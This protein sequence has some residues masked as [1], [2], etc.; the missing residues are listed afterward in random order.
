[1]LSLCVPAVRYEALLRWSTALLGTARGVVLCNNLST[2]AG[3]VSR[4]RRAANKHPSQQALVGAGCAAGQPAPSPAT[5]E[6]P[7]LTAVQ[8]RAM[9]CSREV[10]ARQY[11]ESLYDR[12]YSQV[13][14]G[15]LT[16]SRR[17]LLGRQADVHCTQGYSCLSAFQVRL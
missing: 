4:Q 16:P 7:D 2:D 13:L 10:T 3:A 14:V 9:L 5:V 8:A 11:L 15:S 1:M 12:L 17:C 6:L